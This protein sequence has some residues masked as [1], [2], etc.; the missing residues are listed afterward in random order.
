MSF[1]KGKNNLS[2]EYTEEMMKC[3]TYLPKLFTCTAMVHLSENLS[4]CGYS[5]AYTNGVGLHCSNKPI[6]GVGTDSRGNRSF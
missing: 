4:L 2:K 6:G 3:G 1:T 5:F